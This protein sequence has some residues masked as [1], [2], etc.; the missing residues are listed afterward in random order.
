MVSTRSKLLSTSLVLGMLFVSG[1][2]QY[3]VDVAVHPDGGGTR[4]VQLSMTSLGEK[5]YEPTLDE[6]RQLF[7]VTAEAG[8]EMDWQENEEGQKTPLFTKTARAKDKGSWEQMGGDIRIS[9]TF[10]SGS[11]YDVELS[12]SVLVE[13][14]ATDSGTVISYTETLRWSG[15]HDAA[16]G[17]LVDRFCYELHPAFPDLDETEI[18]ELRALLASHL[19][20]NLQAFLEDQDDEEGPR[21]EIV[22][23]ARHAM[24]IIE[25]EYQDVQLWTICEIFEW[26]VK[27]PGDAISR[28]VE[29][30][31]PGVH[32][33]GFTNVE[34]EVTMPG[35][36]IETNAD[37]VEGQRA[38]WKCGLLDAFLQPVEFYVRSSLS[39]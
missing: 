5:R 9:G 23:L 39:R 17:F 6:L 2:K 7:W 27:D 10:E 24:G 18:V 37:E 20:A 16:V 19:S 35:E 3:E 4:T 33:A 14:E 36:I 31:L 21:P 13:Q 29:R 8:W 25:R 26:V 34:L 11:P 30:E 22:A 32:L 15:L 28:F 38:L 12:N 1:C